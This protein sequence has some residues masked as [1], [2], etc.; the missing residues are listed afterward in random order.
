M[1]AHA[2]VVVFDYIAFPVCINAGN[3]TPPVCIVA[4]HLLTE[5]L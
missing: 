3:W 1:C 2:Y 4:N 5:L